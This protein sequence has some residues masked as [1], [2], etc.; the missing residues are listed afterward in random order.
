MTRWRQFL[1][2]A[3][4]DTERSRELAS[5]IDLETDEN[6]AR[7]M[8]PDEARRAALLKLGNPT[9]IREDIYRLNSLAWLD[10]IG[11]DT[12]HA[13][14]RLSSTPVYA[15]VAVLTLAVGIAIN[16]TVFSIV[17]AVL[18]QPMAAKDPDR[19]VSVF[20]STDPASPY[21]PS[22]YPDYLDIEAAAAEVMT[23]VA[24]SS[25]APVDLRGGVRARLTAGTVSGNYFD[26]L[27]IDPIVGTRFTAHDHGPPVPRF[28]ALLNEKT[29]RETFGA[30]PAI[31]GQTIHLN[32]RLYTVIGVIARPNCTIRRFFE[33]D[34]FVPMNTR[35]ALT[36]ESLTSRQ[37]RQYFLI[38]RLRPS[39]TVAQA[40]TRMGLAAATLATQDPKNWRTP[41][42][43]A[44]SIAVLP[45]RAARV[46][47]SARLGA[48][49]FLSF[50][51][52]M[53]GIVLLIACT[54]L[55]TGALARA[56][57]RRR[58]MA[59][60]LAIGSTRGRL[61]QQL[62][63]ESVILAVLGSTAAWWLANWMIHVLMAIDLHAEVSIRLNLVLDRRVWWFT[64]V[65]TVLTTVISGL[66]P[67]LHAARS[68]IVAALKDTGEATTRRK[69]GLRQ[70][71]VVAAVALSVTL[72]VPAGLFIRSV[73]QL[74][75]VD[76]GFDPH[77]VALVSISL[78]PAD[79]AARGAETYRQIL[80]RIRTMPQVA[81]ADLAV[82][83]PLSGMLNSKSLMAVDRSAVHRTA[84]YNAVGPEYF[85]T[86]RIPVRQ[87]RA[88]TPADGMGRPAVAIVNQALANEMWPG[89]VAVGKRLA[90]TDKPQATME[91]VGVVPTVKFDAVNENATAG[92]YLPILQDFSTDVVLHI[93]TRGVPERA[94]PA[95]DAAVRAVNPSLTAFA[96]RTMDQQIAV[97][98]GP[99]ATAARILV[100]LGTAGLGLACIGLYSVVAYST[101]RRQ[102]EIAIRMTIGADR[103]HIL[104]LLTRQGAALVAIGLAMGLPASGAI[105]LLAS[106][107]LF[108]VQPTDLATYLGAS[109][110]LAVA[111]MGAVFLPAYRATG[112][113]PADA[114]RTL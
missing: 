9:R 74:G 66:T 21:R 42:G 1:R 26:L 5:Y 25:I 45:E 104:G 83:V 98:V 38:G 103:R 53:V 95:F 69:W 16:T 48:T 22:S 39:V 24:A 34:V 59:V 2:R 12:R 109:I 10:A 4:W 8:S 70:A 90:L 112:V 14:R 63:T 68:D 62:L 80:E 23:G 108:D 99:F 30:D 77:G 94:L 72:L 57:A 3:M 17:N 49:A 100:A 36:G 43:Q 56:L 67:A 76:L 79:E 15:V 97:A 91:V 44:G 6:V 46:P 106:S 81:S 31:V 107:L 60:R 65:I 89:E 51:Q 41:A 18:L 88:F 52:A 13:F 113:Q 61:V 102:R 73:Q 19:L 84:M 110:V 54:N 37:A 93:R 105:A 20:T 29:W 27:G 47:P 58:E 28:D 11:R 85:S 55:A 101:A 78:D 87:G 40:A 33:V 86:L 71:L 111:A 92:L 50:V 32:S 96:P 114:L 82:N 64:L 75:K 7:G 35:A